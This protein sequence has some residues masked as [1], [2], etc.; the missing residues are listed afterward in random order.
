MLIFNIFQYISY[1]PSYHQKLDR[2]KGAASTGKIKNVFC[3]TLMIKKTFCRIIDPN[4]WSS[5]IQRSCGFWQASC[6]FKESHSRS[7]RSVG[8]SLRQ[9]C[10]RRIQS[11]SVGRTSSSCQFV[12]QSSHSWWDKQS[13]NYH[14]SPR[15]VNWLFS[16][17]HAYLF[18]SSIITLF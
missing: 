2:S 10:I 14:D 4:S 7:D 17:V 1:E 12:I 13:G 5:E 3:L 11:G 6:I 9:Q 16:L 18:F 15:G 8:R